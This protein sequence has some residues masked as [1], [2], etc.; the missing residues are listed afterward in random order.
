MCCTF[1]TSRGCLRAA[2]C[3]SPWMETFTSLMCS[4]RIPGMTTSATPASHTRKPSSRNNPSPSRSSTVSLPLCVRSRRR[5]LQWTQMN[6]TLFLWICACAWE[7]DH[8]QFYVLAWQ[9]VG[10]KQHFLSL[11]SFPHPQRRQWLS[12][13]W[14]DTLSGPSWHLA[15]SARQPFIFLLQ[16]DILYSRPPKTTTLPY[17]L[18]FAVD[19]TAD[20]SLLMLMLILTMIILIWIHFCFSRFH[21]EH[22]HLFVFVF[23]YISNCGVFDFSVVLQWMHSMTQWQLF[24]MTLICLVVSYGTP[25][26]LPLT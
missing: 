22:I 15:L 9:H 12:S 6:V 13:H 17:I 3:P 24:T 8:S 10:G 5:A 4:E 16:W 18:T 11:I 14:K 25:C 7:A 1:Q 21:F 20:C 23:L 26:C 2:G 19:L